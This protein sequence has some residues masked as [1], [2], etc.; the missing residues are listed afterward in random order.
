LTFFIHCLASERLQLF[1]Q[2]GHVKSSNQFIDL[3]FE[4]L[5]QLRVVGSFV[6]QLLVHILLKLDLLELVKEVLR[7]LSEL[8]VQLGEL[9][10]T[11]CN[12]LVKQIFDL[13]FLSIDYINLIV[14][15]L[16]FKSEQLNVLLVFGNVGVDFL[17][18]L[19]KQASV[20]LSH[21][22][23]LEPVF[24]PVVEHLHIIDHLVAPSAK[25]FAAAVEIVSQVAQLL[26]E[27][28]DVDLDFRETFLVCFQVQML[29]GLLQLL[30]D[31]ILKH[32][33]LFND[34]S[35]VFVD[36]DALPV[37]FLVQDVDQV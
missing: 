30:D 11:A 23:I 6:S 28:V 26:V 17:H 34:Q 20:F 31:S 25:L 5:E 32:A 14:R 13:V 3:I 24:V 22:V 10:L 7:E 29:R 2:L 19:L 9:F 4:L 12:T 8:E 27:V 37:H 21:V 35:L 1:P 18:G 33:K 15:L 36:Q 16:D